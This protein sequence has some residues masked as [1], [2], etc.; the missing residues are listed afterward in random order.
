VNQASSASLS[1]RDLLAALAI[2]LIRRWPPPMGLSALL[3]WGFALAS[4]LLSPLAL[5]HA[6]GHWAPPA[7]WILAAIGFVAGPVG[8]WCV[9][10]AQQGLP[11]V[12]SGVGFLL[13][14]ALG[15]VLS[16][17]W[18]GEPLTGDVIAG[19]GLILGGAGIAVTGRRS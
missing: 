10:G 4:V 13:I 18:L 11:V 7:L 8:T 17:L 9:M 14:P 12:V 15:V 6:T 2:V 1:G 5:S 19:A 3:P 16:A